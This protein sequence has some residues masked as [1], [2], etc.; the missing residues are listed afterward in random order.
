M[1]VP[2]GNI[3]RDALFYELAVKTIDNRPKFQRMSRD[4]AKG[5]FDVVLV[6]V[7]FANFRKGIDKW[8][9]ML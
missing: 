1:R 2:Y 3:I 6:C 8:K 9:N 7:F 5:L 4:S